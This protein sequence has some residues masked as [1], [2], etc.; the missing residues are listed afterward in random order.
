MI[1]WIQVTS[2][3]EINGGLYLNA[4][5][6]GIK[7]SGFNHKPKG[8]S[9]LEMSTSNETR[10]GK[11]KWLITTYVLPQIQLVGYNTSLQSLPWLDSPYKLEANIINSYVWII[12]AGINLSYNRFN[13][14]YLVQSR[15]KE[16]N[17][18]QPAW[19]S[20]GGITMGCSF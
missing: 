9:Q 1:D 17:K 14:T 11:S 20:W 2:V 3:L 8:A 7:F 18:F 13:L 19:H 10:Y 15:T 4:V 16:F 5:K 12:E 6:G